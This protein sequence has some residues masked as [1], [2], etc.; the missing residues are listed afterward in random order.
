MARDNLPIATMVSGQKLR[1]HKI[2]LFD[3]PSMIEVMKLRAQA[4]QVLGSSAGMIGVFGTPSLTLAAEAVALGFVSGILNQ[5]AKKAA[6]ENLKKAQSVV[7]RMRNSFVLFDTEEIENLEMPSPGTWCAV[8]GT[9]SQT[10]NINEIPKDEADE[11][12]RVHNI[13]R[14]WGDPTEHTVSVPLRY[15]H[16]GDDFVFAITDEGGVSFRWSQVESYHCHQA[17]VAPTSV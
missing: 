14:G 3:E 2:R 17:A 1:L 9:R 16:D 13:K 4:A 15:V 6:L 10:V 5:V 8:K 11:F 7:D 12:C